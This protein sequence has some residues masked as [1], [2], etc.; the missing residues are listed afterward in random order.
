MR[1]RLV[2]ARLF[3]AMACKSSNPISPSD[4]LGGTWWGPVTDDRS[5]SGLLTLELAAQPG[6]GLTGTWSSAF[7][8]TA[9]NNGGT[10]SAAAPLGSPL[11]FGMDCA[12]MGAALFT[13]NVQGSRMSGTYSGV[14]C[15]GL[16]RGTV[17][18][19]KQ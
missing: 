14:M 8:D 19:T 12:Q 6:G 5:G 1:P 7:S 3:F 17:A 10:L 11:V 2:A 4:S 15:R 16:E 9:S 18:L 13:M